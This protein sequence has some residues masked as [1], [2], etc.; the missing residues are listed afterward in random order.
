[1]NSFQEKRVV[2]VFG[3]EMILRSVK[4]KGNVVEEEEA[5]ESD[6]AENDKDFICCS[7]LF[8]DI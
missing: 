5:N 7:L 3:Y 8:P 1:M 2:T 6:N 4:K